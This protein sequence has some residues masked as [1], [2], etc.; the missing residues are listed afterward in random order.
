MDDSTDANERLRKLG[1][2]STQTQPEWLQQSIVISES[3]VETATSW[4]SVDT[5]PPEPKKESVEEA[6]IILRWLRNM[7]FADRDLEEFLD[8]GTPQTIVSKKEKLHKLTEIF[9]Q[10][11]RYMQSVNPESV[12]ANAAIQNARDAVD[13]VALEVT[14]HT[15]TL[16][17]DGSPEE[18]K[19]NALID[20]LPE[21]AKMRQNQSVEQLLDTMEL[22]MAKLTGKAVE[23]SE[24]E[25]LKAASAQMELNTKILKSP[26]TM[27]KP[28]REESIELAREILRR[29]K[30]MTFGDKTLAEF[31]SVANASEKAAFAQQISEVTDTYKNLLAEATSSNPELRENP[32][33]KAATDAINT[34]RHSIS[35]MAVKEIPVSMASTMQISAE[36]D[37]AA[38]G[39]MHSKTIDRLVKSASDA[40]EKAI[41][42]VTQQQDQDRAEEQ[43]QDSAAQQAEQQAAA[44]EKSKKK[45]HKGDSKPRSSGKGGRRQRKKEQE[46]S[47]DDFILKQGRFAV[48]APSESRTEKPTGKSNAPRSSYKTGETKKPSTPTGM[49]GLKESDL[50]AIRQLGGSLRG[51][52]DQLRSMGT[53]VTTV[54]TSDRVSPSTRSQTD[55][56]KDREK[57]NANRPGP[58]KGGPSV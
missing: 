57:Q 12:S 49:A 36:A 27:D 2:A 30:N 48:E 34:F 33:V 4:Q 14:E 1:D 3:I 46:V 24:F 25:R 53:T 37:A 16:T 26:H 20:R 6:R 58:K 51:I 45:R 5:L 21:S 13:T 50:Q 39:N 22:G 32:I 7:Q 9:G 56:L 10:H 35:L 31:M 8:Q 28:A 17:P 41:A 18:L 47:A 43:G 52:G 55:Q 23:L 15:R 19:L 38:L 54:S 44:N 11:L 40:M 42:A 29:L